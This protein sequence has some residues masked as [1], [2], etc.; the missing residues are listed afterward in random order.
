MLY[1]LSS[2]QEAP[3]TPAGPAN[4][5]E[6]LDE[7]E[8]KVNPDHPN[9]GVCLSVILNAVGRRSYG[10]LILLVGLI[11]VSPI[12][13][14]P[15]MTWLT[16]FVALLIAG[17][18]ALGFER[19]WLPRRVLEAKVPRRALFFSLDK[20]RPYA[21]RIDGLLE[22]R[23][24]F[25][26]TPPFLNIIALCCVG[27]ALITIPLSLIPIAP[28]APSLALVLFGLGVTARD[29]VWLAIGLALCVLACWLVAPLL[30]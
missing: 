9:E 17:Q 23:L 13:V 15:G 8:A 6:M 21:A 3:P 1:L 19:P 29:G 24:T 7:V 26:S 25:L 14:I 20:G 30:F 12:T 22:E 11:A 4:L 18:M 5:T 2:T 28:L 27:A 16:A 10:P